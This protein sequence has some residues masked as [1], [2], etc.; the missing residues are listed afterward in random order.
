MV[1]IGKCFYHL[2]RKKA[3]LFECKYC[4]EYFCKEHL[5][6]EPA[7]LP[8]FRDTNPEAQKF[9]EGFHK[10][11]GHPC[12]PYT[13]TLDEKERKEKE[14]N[15]EAWKR[16]DEW[17]KK[18]GK[19]IVLKSTSSEE[20]VFISKPTKKLKKLSQ[21]INEPIINYRKLI[22]FII[23]IL[24]FG[25]LVYFLGNFETKISFE[26]KNIT[27]SIFGDI[28]DFR[29]QN[30]LPSLIYNQDAYKMTIYLANRFYDTNNYFIS[31]K[32][33]KDIQSKYSLS[34]IEILTIKL[35]NLNESQF[36]SMLNS[37]TNKEI[38]SKKILNKSFSDGALGCYKEACVLILGEEVKSFLTGNVINENTSN[39]N[40]ISNKSLENDRF[41]KY[42]TNEK[43]VK[44]TYFD[45][46]VYGGLNNYLSNLDR[47]I[48]YYYIPPTNRDFIMKDLDNEVQH[49]FLIPLVE[50]IKNRK[51]TKKEQADMAISLV[52]NIPY[53][54]D[55][56]TSGEL[57]GKYPYEV[58]Y[59]NTGVC[60]EKSELLAYLLKELG[61]GVA[62]FEFEKESH[63]AVGIKCNNGNYGTDYCFIETTD[64]YPMR[65]I[66]QEYVGGVDIRNA[67]PKLIIISD[68][69]TYD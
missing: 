48:S 24:V 36:D 28:N 4:K 38:F 35:D 34:N 29:R 69:I 59:E 42:K 44:L 51:S 64:Y 32:E 6:P 53:D 33:L 26:S 67:Q 56:F 55:G 37:W 41:S 50:E 18:V 31:E 3:D 23:F 43:I 15:D 22:Y 9:M 11:F 17:K 62:I 25:F 47:S 14:K 54:W 7:G 12:F 63:R 16:Y 61:F 58:L 2:H 8:R 57:N 66:P 1:K 65:Q 21:P 10:D 5:K 68:G 40:L 46:T 52:Q 49:E 60:G 39:T 13:R 30:N 19:S 27:N 45:F 20:N